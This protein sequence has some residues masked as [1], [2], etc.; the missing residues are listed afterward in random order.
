[1]SKPEKAS[2]GDARQGGRQDSRWK[3]KQATDLHYASEES[4]ES[5]DECSSAASY[6]LSLAMTSAKNTGDSQQIVYMLSHRDAMQVKRVLSMLCVE[7][8]HFSST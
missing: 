5:Q 2:Q 6:A 8:M 7:D 1:M 3:G 4:R